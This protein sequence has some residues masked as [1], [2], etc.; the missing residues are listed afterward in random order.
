MGEVGIT[1]IPAPESDLDFGVAWHYGDPHREQRLLVAGEAS[2][3]LSHWGVVTV[4]GVDRL[5]WLHSLTTAFLEN[6]GPH[7]SRIALIL[8]PHGHVEQE[9]HV[10][11]DGETT[12][13]ITPPNTATA[14]TAY[15]N[16]MRFMLRVEVTDVSEEFAVV[17]EPVHALDP[18]VI[19][20]LTP[21]EFSGAG[22]AGGG[23]AG[24][25]YAG[26]GYVDKYVAARPELFLGRQVIVPRL[27][28]AE[29]LDQFPHRAGTWAYNAI[30]AAA[31]VP[32][33]ARE[34]DHKS[35][36]HEL[37]WIGSGVHLQKGCYR[38]QETV[39]RV[40]NL[41]KPPRRLVLL[42]L[43]G[44]DSDLPSHG[45]EVTTAAG[46][47]IGFIATPARHFELGPIAT[48]VIKRSTP[49]DETLHVLHDGNVI[50]ANQELVVTNS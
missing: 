20:W 39:A 47:V 5:S 22:T 11:D 3:D 4:T 10:V 25:G 28:L 41:G 43:D 27:M 26:E 29:R 46:K 40:Y 45:D 31:A 12:W 21:N 50:T 34:T 23:S 18:S 15:L 36:P 33:L 9:L 48:A 35:L 19:T 2:V 1:P 30:R 14:L 38:G 24:E 17:W 13:L 44:S 37:G 49:V 32:Q 6:L 8:S 42:H 16:S 7:V